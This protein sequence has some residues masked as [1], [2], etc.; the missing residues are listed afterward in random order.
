MIGD[1]PGFTRIQVKPMPKIDDYER[2]VLN[3]FD[4]H[5]AKSVVSKTKLGKFKAAARAPAILRRFRPS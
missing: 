2:E 5:Q 1:Q 3:A 4:K